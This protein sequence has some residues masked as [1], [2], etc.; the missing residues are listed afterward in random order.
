MIDLRSDTVTQPTPQM[1]RFLST[2]AVGDD[3]YGQDPSVLELE[4][5]CKDLFHVEA[6]L[7]TTSGM[8]SN[9]LAIL[10]QTSPGDEVITDY[11]YHVNF[12]DSASTA[13]ICHVVLNTPRT[14][15]G[16]LSVDLVE[17][18][19][20]SKPRYHHFAQVKLIS[21]E[22]T[23]NGHRGK[24]FPFEDLQK[25]YSYAHQKDLSVHLDGARLF[26][27]HVQTQIPLSA[28]AAQAD[29]ISVCFSKGLGAPFGSMLMGRR[30]IIEKAKRL[31]GWLGSGV[32]QIGIM[33]GAALYAIQNHIP[34][35]KVDH[36]NATY[37]ESHLRILP[38][39]SVPPDPVET[40]IVQFGIEKLGVSN[41][42]FLA[43]CEKKGLLLFPWLPEKIRAVLHQPLTQQDMDQTLCILKDVIHSFRSS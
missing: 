13:A 4:A 31:R 39:L 16:I 9:R 40:N 28:F 21:V 32:H 18:T 42:L 22:N 19:L 5:Y 1:R 3:A 37:L 33:A 20:H 10:A 43:A 14:K 34:L 41:D 25:L 15:S 27:A 38:E 24:I 12:F 7:F 2:A 23:I 35:L 26:N 30:E 11:N 36:E 6:A 17:K 8:L 29:T